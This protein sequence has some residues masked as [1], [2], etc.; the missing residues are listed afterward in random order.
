MLV[1][2]DQGMCVWVIDHGNFAMHWHD[3]ITS[4]LANQM[5]N[6]CTR[7]R[8]SIKLMQNCLEFVL[9]LLSVM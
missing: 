7:L 9:E 2:F 8:V 6:V 3:L 5:V 1:S 4:S